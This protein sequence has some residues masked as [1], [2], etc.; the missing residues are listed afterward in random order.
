MVVSLQSQTQFISGNQKM[1]QKDL[2]VEI[3]RWINSNS[4]GTLAE[5]TGKLFPSNVLWMRQGRE[6]SAWISVHP[7][8][9]NGTELVSQEWKNTLFLHDI[10]EPPD[11]PLYC[12]GGGGKYNHPC[13]KLK[14]LGL[15][16]TQH[17]NLRYRVAGLYS[18]AFRLL[19]VCDNPLIHT[20]FYMQGV[21]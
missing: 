6:A 12:N 3:W 15:V 9:F 20:G 5:V 2:R 8:N 14:N 11:L 16:I 21:K 10:V 1:T 13:T 19:H 7:S 18:K 17:T 4:I